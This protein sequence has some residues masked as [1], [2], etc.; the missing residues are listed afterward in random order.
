ML[1]IY[2]ESLRPGEPQIHPT[3]GSVLLSPGG[4]QPGNMYHDWRKEEKTTLWWEELPQMRLFFWYPFVKSNT[5]P[6]LPSAMP[7][8]H[9]H[10]WPSD[11][12]WQA[13]LLFNPW[14]HNLD[15]SS[16]NTGFPYATACIYHSSSLWYT[17]RMLTSRVFLKHTFIPT[18]WLCL[19]KA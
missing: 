18:A 15:S 12:K 10:L 3:W 4:G 19:R 16:T 9:L 17:S 5:M 11:K 13:K 8:A 14:K 2:P 1:S 6:Q 7:P